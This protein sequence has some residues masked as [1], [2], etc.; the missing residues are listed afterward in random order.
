[1]VRKSKVASITNDYYYCICSGSFVAKDPNYKPLVCKLCSKF[2]H[3]ECTKYSGNQEDFECLLCKVHLLDPFNTVDNFLW[4]ECIG[5]TTSY[6]VV[7][8]TNLRK[9]RSLNKDIY[10]ACIPLN[11]EVL[12]HEWPKTFQLKINNDMVHVVKEPTWEHKR[13]DN[14]IKVTYAMR[15]GENLINITSTTYTETE[16]LFLLVMF[17]CNQV[18]VQNIIDTLKMNHTVPYEEARDRIYS[19]LNAKIDDDEIVCMESTHKMDL[20]C[21]VTLD[22]ITIPTRGRYCRHIQCYD[23]FGYLKVMERTSAFNMRWKCPECHLI[24]KPF[25]LVIDTYVE[26]LITDL[27]NVKTIQLDKDLNYRIILDL[28]NGRA[29][30]KAQSDDDQFNN[31]EDMDYVADLET[32]MNSTTDNVIELESD[33]PPVDVICI[34]DDDVTVEEPV[35]EVTE[36]PKPPAPRGRPRKNKPVEKN[37]YNSSCVE[38]KVK[39]RKLKKPSDMSDTISI[40]IADQ[41]LADCVNT[42]NQQTLHSFTNSTPTYDNFILKPPVINQMN[43]T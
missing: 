19:I 2:S 33:E 39:K 12:Q 5:N 30:T 20:T 13:R 6:F 38:K 31:D 7:D 28:N 42:F 8:A 29:S 18:T 26:K 21:P 37:V 1:M 27:P 11:K 43:K 41:T 25:D 4:Y 32:T 22:K 3:R 24:V 36:V 10:M 35:P 15:T 14:P 9:W 17:V 34:S 23:L 40:T 16:P